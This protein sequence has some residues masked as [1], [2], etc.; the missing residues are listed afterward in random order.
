[1]TGINW[2]S[3]LELAL[4]SISWLWALQFFATTDWSDSAPW[5]VDLLLG[6]DRQLAHVEH[7]LSY[8]FS[9]NTHL[10]G[11]ALA[12]YVASR[13]LPE[14]PAGGRGDAIGRRVLVAEIDR[15]IAGDGG[16]CERSAHYHRYTLD[17][18]LLALA[19]ARITDDSAA[20]DFEHA[21]ER[22]SS[23]ARLLAHD[24][25]RLPH[26]GDD[27]GGA[28]FPITGRDPDDARGSLAVAAA[29]L[30]DARLQIGETPEE[31]F[32]VLGEGNAFQIPHS[33]FQIPSGALPETGYYVSRSADGD[34]LVID[35]G[36]HGYQ[37]GGHAHPDALS[38]TFSWRCVPLIIDPGTACHTPD[39][40]LRDRMRSAAMHNTLT[41]D[42]RSPSIPD[43]AFH[44]KQTVDARASRWVTGDTFDYFDG[45]HD[46]YAPIEHRRQVL[47]RHG[48]LL[49]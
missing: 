49:V 35:A 7:N 29:L 1:L 11:E 9:R 27:D 36:P 20:A 45:A 47:A 15:Q 21:A 13:A 4:R 8:Y 42:G 31:A 26:L 40:E 41:I 23:A 6:I 46:G 28:L 37:N 18:Y 38:L 12:L 25:G 44:W 5:I 10:I 19:I 48:D 30:N 2:A 16:H 32:W 34:H 17:F 14:L 33:K 39:A 22:L 3:M 43:G 24:D